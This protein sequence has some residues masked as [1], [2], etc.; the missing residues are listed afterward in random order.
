MLNYGSSIDDLRRFLTAVQL[1]VSRVNAHRSMEGIS[2]ASQCRKIMS[3]L[4]DSLE[5]LYLHVSSHPKHTNIHWLSNFILDYLMLH[6]DRF[7]RNKARSAV[8]ESHNTP[9]RCTNSHCRAPNTHVYSDCL[10]EGGG[11]RHLACKQC[12]EGGHKPSRC[13]KQKKKGKTPAKGAQRAESVASTSRGLSF[14]AAASRL[15]R[16][17]EHV[18]IVDSGSTDHITYRRDWF[19]DLEPCSTKIICAN[20]EPMVATGVGTVEF[21]VRDDEGRVIPMKLSNVLL[22]PTC[23]YNLYSPKVASKHGAELVLSPNGSCLR[24]GPASLPIDHSSSDYLLHGVRPTVRTATTKN[25]LAH[26]RFGHAGQTVMKKLGYEVDPGHPCEDC[27]ITGMTRAPVPD[28]ASSQQGPATHKRGDLVY[29]D[30]FIMHKEGIRG[31][32]EVA[33]CI[34]EGT[35]VSVIGLIGPK[36]STL[37]FVQ[38]SYRIFRFRTL[39]SDYGSEFVNTKVR[40]FLSMAQVKY[41]RSTPYVHEEIGSMERL[42]RKLHSSS[43]A[44][45]RWSQLPQSFWP[46]AMVAANHVRN[47]LP[48]VN[49]KYGGKTPYELLY[50][51]QPDTSH[52]RVWGCVAYCYI[53][54]EKRNKIE[55]RAFKGVFIGYAEEW[56]LDDNNYRSWVIWNP[57]ASLYSIAQCKIC[58]RLARWCSLCR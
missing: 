41:E 10:F 4:P 58:R 13:R 52:L 39:R 7:S 6:E 54:K 22:V 15:G 3:A 20:E 55:P 2:E 28:Q 48:A 29:F 5:A 56:N 12:P 19:T 35:N 53:P 44:M 42:W 8:V 37:S 50:S 25:E 36:L 49:Q 57:H 24:Q 1:T 11:A 46:Y 45:L 47:R 33:G 51:A 26:R 43:R 17:D 9:K 30:T 21:Q 16:G 14:S 40:D 23:G 38:E 27:V 34:D 18:W 31:H 32:K